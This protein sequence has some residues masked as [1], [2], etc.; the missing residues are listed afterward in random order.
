[1]LI[2]NA[3]KDFQFFLVNEDSNDFF[4]YLPD[5]VCDWNEIYVHHHFIAKD[6]Y[7]LL[8]QFHNVDNAFYHYHC[9]VEMDVNHYS[10]YDNNL[11]IDFVNV[12]YNKYEAD[13]FCV[14]IG[15]EIVLFNN[16]YF[17]YVKKYFDLFQ[18][19]YS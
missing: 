14:D 10:F 18:D 11:V 7:S 19:N 4:L 13:Q 15:I 3:Y 6:F 8:N 2:F 16:F 1:M 12:T 9:H 17:L 5:V